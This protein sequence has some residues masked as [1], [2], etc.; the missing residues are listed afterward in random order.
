[1]GT[2]LAAIL[3]TLSLFQA[4]TA[5]DKQDVKEFIHEFSISKTGRA[6]LSSHSE[7]NL[8]KIV[9]FLENPVTYFD[10]VEPIEGFC[11]YIS[12]Y[13]A[14]L[15]INNRIP[16]DFFSAFLDKHFVEVDSNKVRILTFLLAGCQASALFAELLAERY[17]VLFGSNPQ[18]FIRDL[19]TRKNWKEIMDS[20]R[21]GHAREFQ[22]GLA[23]LGDSSFEKEL[24][25]Y[26]RRPHKSATGRLEAVE[27]L[28]FIKE[29]PVV[30]QGIS[31]ED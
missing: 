4:L 1:M 15:I 7:E 30:F 16:G 6:F 10:N 11:E 29:D 2:K 24:K 13:S 5:A 8:K 3:I 17:T 12:A 31:D 26:V 23:K 28:R 18:I 19:E 27:G 25:E 22:A 9:L 21:S 20:L 14:F